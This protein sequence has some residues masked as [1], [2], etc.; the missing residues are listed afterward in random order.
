[1][2]IGQP[3]HT[4]FGRSRLLRWS[5]G[6][7]VHFYHTLHHS[8][9]HTNKRPTRPPTRYSMP[10]NNKPP[11]IAAAAAAGFG[12]TLDLDGC[13]FGDPPPDGDARPRR[14]R[15]HHRDHPP[16]DCVDSLS[17]SPATSSS[18]RRRRPRPPATTTMQPPSPMGGT[19]RHEGISVGRDFL[20]FRGSTLSADLGFDDFEIIGG[21]C[22]GRGSCGSVW[23]A[24]LRPGRRRRGGRGG[25]E[26]GE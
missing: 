14:R 13:R 15:D 26:G 19:Y 24:R 21:C 4:S 1:M 9:L 20:R 23:K 25:G 5:S 2:I 18:S 6:E 7:M 3:K 10:P 8:T 12:L 17:P 22:L 11:G 16:D